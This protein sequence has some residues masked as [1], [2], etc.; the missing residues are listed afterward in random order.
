MAE[1]LEKATATE[2][3]VLTIKK[4]VAHKV[5]A[6]FV[7]RTQEIPAV[8]MFMPTST[9]KLVIQAE[10]NMHAYYKMAIQHPEIQ[11]MINPTLKNHPLQ[12]MW[13]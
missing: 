9:K 10:N 12:G 5:N 3:H 2:Q 4:I 11:I 8:E 6:I 7:S 1:W 13:Q